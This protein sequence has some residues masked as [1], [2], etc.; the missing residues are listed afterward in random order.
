MGRVKLLLVDGIMAFVDVS[1]FH[2]A[3]GSAGCVVL[4]RSK[5]VWLV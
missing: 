2:G 3:G 5:I 1:G 4:L